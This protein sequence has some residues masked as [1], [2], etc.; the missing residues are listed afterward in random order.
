[1]L[2]A[3]VSFSKWRAFWRIWS[4][5]VTTGFMFHKQNPGGCVRGY[6]GWGKSRLTGVSTQNTVYS[7]YYYLL[8]IVFF[9]IWTTVNLLLLHLVHKVANESWKWKWKEEPG[10]W[11]LLQRQNLQTS[12]LSGLRGRVNRRRSQTA[13]VS[14]LRDWGMELC[15]WLSYRTK[16]VV[17]AGS[18][19]LGK[20][21]TRFAVLCVKFKMHRGDQ[22]RPASHWIWDW[23]S[24]GRGWQ[25]SVAYM[26]DSAKSQN[27]QSKK[28]KD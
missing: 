12:P 15:C 3:F 25:W 17:Q 2:G 28:K 5:R 23:S 18:G 21:N 10:T 1:M 11:E 6:T 24:E 26:G 9:P 27:S 22:V 8:I 7:S 4:R 19:S 13:E 16:V 20:E 14:N